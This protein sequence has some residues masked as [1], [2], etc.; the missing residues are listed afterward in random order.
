MNDQLKI[1]VAGQEKVSARR[2]AYAAPVLE[3]FGN[4]RAITQAVGEVGAM[5]GASGSPNKTSLK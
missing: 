5:D 1:N 2:K 4:I 3:E